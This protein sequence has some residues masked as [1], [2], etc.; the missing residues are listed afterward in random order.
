LCAVVALIALLGFIALVGVVQAAPGVPFGLV[1]AASTEDGF[2]RG[3]N[4][5]ADASGQLVLVWYGDTA[6]EPGSDIFARR[7]AATGVPLGAAFRVNAERAGEQRRPVVGV[8][9]DGSFV[10]AWDS[11]TRTV[12]ARRFG[13]DGTPR[14]DDIAVS[15][16]GARHR[17]PAIAVAADGSFA[18]V[19]E[20]AARGDSKVALRRFSSSGDALGDESV[21]P[22]DPGQGALQLNPA[23]ATLADGR[24]AVVWEQTELTA[25]VPASELWLQPIGANGLA[26][27]AALA[28]AA[29]TGAELRDPAIAVGPDGSMLVAWAAFSVGDGAIVVRSFDAAGQVLGPATTV[30]PVTQAERS[31]PALVISADGSAAAAWLE[32]SA[33][34]AQLGAR[35]MSAAGTP[36]GEPLAARTEA[37]AALPASPPALALGPVA[38]SPL[39]LSWAQTPPDRQEEAHSAVYAR[40]YVEALSQLHLPL[41]GR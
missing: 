1:L 32:G 2:F 9:A 30:S 12:W 21:L 26:A 24:M 8:A 17:D 25:L 27:G 34:T 3:Q 35:L 20:L 6:A 40:R 14:G 31:M 19:W 11:D 22:S 10:V 28:V 4:A 29:S 37:Q 36:V 33:A 39:W 23:V 41:L 13:P 5:A 16:S 18:V 15:Q 38:S 7:F